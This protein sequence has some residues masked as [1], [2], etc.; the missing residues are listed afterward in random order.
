MLKY[1]SNANVEPGQ[2]KLLD[3]E[4][5][6]ER[7]ADSLQNVPGREKHDPEWRAAKEWEEEQKRLAREGL[8]IP[9]ASELLMARGDSCLAPVQRTMSRQLMWKRSWRR[10]TFSPAAA[11]RA[12]RTSRKSLRREPMSF[13][14]KSRMSAGQTSPTS[15]AKICWL[16]GTG[17]PTSL[18]DFH[19]WHH[20][21]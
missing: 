6:C 13:F 11:K 3:G 14:P 12:S 17:V 20:L 8:T 5:L 21:F 7:Q 19:R 10:R 9:T 4:S 16:H 1:F 18:R 2:R 15:T